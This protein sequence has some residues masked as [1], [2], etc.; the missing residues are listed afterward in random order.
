MA[1]VGREEVGVDGL[2]GLD[3]DVECFC[4]GGKGVLTRDDM[5]DIN[6]IRFSTTVRNDCLTANSLETRGK[7]LLRS[8]PYR[9]SF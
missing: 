7:L 6:E 2:Q 1:A 9:L 3:F 8:S 5:V 4:R